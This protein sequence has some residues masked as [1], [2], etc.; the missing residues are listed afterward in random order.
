[1]NLFLIIA[2]YAFE[3]GLNTFLLIPASNDRFSCLSLEA[4]I[5]RVHSES[6][7]N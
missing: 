3:H 6:I 2:R 4:V 5:L 7:R 1:M